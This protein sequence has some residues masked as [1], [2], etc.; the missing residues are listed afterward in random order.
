M[1][2]TTAK[3]AARLNGVREVSL[4]GFADLGYWRKQL[5]PER[6]A[7]IEAD[8]RAQVLIIAA[9]ARFKGVRFRELSFSIQARPLDGPAS[10]EGVFLV[11][12]FS[13]NPFFAWC[14]RR[15]FGTPYFHG[16][17]GVTAALPA[18]ID[19]SLAGATA[20]HAE[21]LPEAP[22]APPRTPRRAADDGWEGPVYL[23]TPGRR[24]DGGKMFFARVRGLTE[25]YEFLPEDWLS[26][27]PE[28]PIFEHLISSNY[29]PAQ[30]LLRP[31]AAHAK[32][33]T[34]RRDE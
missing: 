24:A 2:I 30:W 34:Y 7:P 29:A 3:W 23:P 6:L 11:Q 18:A 27:T 10:V 25:T 31:S 12:A 21:M 33:K 4:A 5:A 17:V 14:E 22:G 28:A 15:L 32:S 1:D 13:T 26:L 16:W 8:G 9:D 20:F 19:L